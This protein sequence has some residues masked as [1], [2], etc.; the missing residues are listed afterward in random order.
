MWMPSHLK[1][2]GDAQS[3]TPSRGRPVGDAHSSY[4]RA[5]EPI[6]FLKKVAWQASKGC[7]MAIHLTLR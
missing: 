1:S 3:G 5:V 6:P 4:L 2:V 7:A